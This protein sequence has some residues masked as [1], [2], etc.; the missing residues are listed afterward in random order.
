M[1]SKGGGNIYIF[2]IQIPNRL[3]LSEK[4]DIFV[5]G[6]A[7]NFDS[8]SPE[9]RA[10]EWVKPSFIWTTT[11]DM[12]VPAENSVLLYSAIKKSG[13]DAELH[14]FS[15][16]PHGL[17]LCDEEVFST[18]P[19]SAPHVGNWIGLSLEFLALRGF[20]CKNRD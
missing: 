19:L 11:T 6:G 1:A 3:N 17:S 12:S 8:Y 5:C 9:K 7:V 10:G 18:L 20:K 2:Q 4:P 16:G 15:D 13:G 14:I